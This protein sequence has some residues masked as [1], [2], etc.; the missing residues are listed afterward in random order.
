MYRFNDSENKIKLV[1][2]YRLIIRMIKV[3][4]SLCKSDNTS[5]IVVYWILVIVS[6]NLHVH[7]YK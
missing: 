7:G 5:F 4:Y 2:L 3:I 6:D 1:R